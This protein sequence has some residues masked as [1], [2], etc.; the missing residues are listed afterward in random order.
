MKFQHEMTYDAA[1]DAVYAMLSEKSFREAVCEAQHVTGCTVD[2]D[3]GDGS[4]KVRVDQHRPADDLPG[5]A[6][7]FVGDDIHIVQ[8]EDWSSP[9]EAKLD[10]GIPGKPGHLKGTITLRKDG[11]ATVE[12]VSGDL[13]VNI[14]MVGGKIEKLI[15]DLLTKALQA[16]QRVGTTW[17]SR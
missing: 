4:M 11:D 12:T 2:I 7:K 15:A 17:L 14:P 6:K 9:T 5:F 3:Q 1:P 8:E 13:K 10:V 16:E